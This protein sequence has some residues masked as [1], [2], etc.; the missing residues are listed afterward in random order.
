MS[1]HRWP[2]LASLAFFHIGLLAACGP[3]RGTAEPGT[4]LEETLSRVRADEMWE[5]V[6]VFSSIDRTS[7]SRGEREAVDHLKAAL[8]RFGILHTV[9]EIEAY[10]SLPISA[11]LDILSPRGYGIPAITPSFSAS[12]PAGGLSGDLVYVGPEEPGIVTTRS[13]D[14]DGVDPRGKIVLLRGYPSPELIDLTVRAGGIG[15][16]CIAPSPRL[17]NMIVSNVWGNPTPEDAGRLPGI[18]IVTVNEN[19]GAELER[20][21]RMGKVRARLAATTDTGWKTIPLLVAEIRGAVDPDRFVLIGNHIDSW[22]EGVTDSATGNGSLL[23]I[24]RVLHENRSALRRSLRIAWWPGHSTGRYAGSTWYAD[25]HFQDLYDN[26][27]AYMAIDSPGVRSATGIEAEGM[28]ETRAIL[29][30]ILERRTGVRHEAIRDM[31]YNDESFWGIGI[32]SMTL[33]PAIPPGHPDRAKDAGGSA[34][35][36][37]WHTKEDSL[38]KADR[39]LL[40]RDTRLFIAVMWPMLTRETL[41][42][43][44]IPVAGQM[45][46]TIESLSIATDGRWDF[47]PTLARIAAFA[48]GAAALQ[49]RA[50]TARGAEARRFNDIYMEISRVLNPVLYTCAG[51]YNHDPAVQYPLFP[52]LRDAARLAAIEATSDEAGFMRTR[53]LRESN[54][55]NQA[56]DRAVMLARGPDR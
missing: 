27:V 19:D 41:P 43:D 38:D 5:V 33:Y 3:H 11:S 6:E 1:R 45:M 39:E 35:G 18:P 12:T 17:V 48:E 34:Y 7:S 54:R 46:E 13:G 21:R 9:H 23:E 25:N 26:A 31:R 42:F 55:V 24:A 28:F 36:Y 15:A 44:F 49:R 51:P 4:G 2:V 37:W 8:E 14:F 47:E 22:H 32:P 30:E 20:L 56:L 29:E 10:L 40:I 52:C 53:L 50:S 16:I